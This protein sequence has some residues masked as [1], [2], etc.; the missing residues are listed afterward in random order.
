MA[1]EESATNLMLVKNEGNP[2]R[3]EVCHTADEFDSELGVCT[4]CKDIAIPIQVGEQE[5]KIIIRDVYDCVCVCISL[6]RMAL[7]L[8][9]VVKMR[10]WEGSFIS[11]VP[12]SGK[13]LERLT[14][15]VKDRD[16]HCR[17]FRDYEI[18]KREEVSVFKR[19]WFNWR[20]KRDT[21]LCE[22]KFVKKVENSETIVD[23]ITIKKVSEDD[24]EWVVKHIANPLSKQRD[25]E[26]EIQ[27]F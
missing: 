1:N 25:A 23:S 26:V 6:T 20:M 2:K 21:L 22:I 14:E 16:C 13:G 27:Y 4:R 5:K 15:Y 19:G 24:L 10:G 8:G 7:K 9:L 11:Y 18:Y 12:E 17:D 3:C